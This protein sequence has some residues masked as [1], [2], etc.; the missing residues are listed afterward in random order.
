MLVCDVSLTALSPLWSPSKRHRP[1]GLWELEMLLG[2]GEG[3][4]RSCL[5]EGERVGRVDSG[6]K[7]VTGEEACEMLAGS[8]PPSLRLEGSSKALALSG[9]RGR[10]SL[11]HRYWEVLKEMLCLFLGTWCPSLQTFFLFNLSASHRC[12]SLTRVSLRERKST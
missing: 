10:V 4:K 6:D 1:S 11:S 12:A 3:R 9:L 7:G 5:G 8:G 2:G